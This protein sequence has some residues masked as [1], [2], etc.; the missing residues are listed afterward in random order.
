MRWQAIV[1]LATVVVMT[2][3][4]ASAQVHRGGHGFGHGFS[5]RGAQFTGSHRHG[6]DAY[7][8]AVSE[9]NDK[10]LATKLKSICRGC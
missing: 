9:E 3:F 1:T 4:T 2:T 6:D 8:N 10:L 7:V 5:G